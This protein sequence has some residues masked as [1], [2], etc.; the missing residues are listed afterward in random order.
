[1]NRR[2]SASV[3]LLIP[4][5]VLLSACV[6]PATARGADVISASSSPSSTPT[7]QLGSRVSAEEALALVRGSQG[8]WRGY[9]MSDGT[10]VVVNKHE[11][12]PDEVQA[13][14]TAQGVQHATVYGDGTS[15]D[16]TYLREREK[17]IAKVGVDTGKR[18]VALLRMTGYDIDENLV[19]RYFFNGP[20]QPDVSY[21]SAAEARAAL[22]AWLSTQE[23]PDDFVVIQ[24][25]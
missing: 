3:V 4:A 2:R 21:G 11:P 9:P 7:P 1:M 23:A 25:E 13:D 6:A 19:T 15:T 22:D 14:V 16:Q 8:E 24:P 20:F 5:L 17:M 12:L 18:V 10:Y